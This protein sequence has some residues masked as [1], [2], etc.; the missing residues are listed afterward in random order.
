MMTVTESA[1]TAISTCVNQNP[2]LYPYYGKMAN[3]LLKN[4]IN[5]GFVDEKE[6]KG[7]QKSIKDESKRLK[8]RGKK[9]LTEELLIYLK[10]F[11]FENEWD[12]KVSEQVRS[13]FT[14]N[15]LI[16]NLTSNTK[17]VEEILNYLYYKPN[18]EKRLDY[19]EFKN[20]MLEFLV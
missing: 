15:C 19:K 9:Y 6:I 14:T 4:L 7:W 16:N 20:F 10:D 12:D 18:L 3:Y 8:D 2:I 1:I 13:L 5:D 11:L 17:E